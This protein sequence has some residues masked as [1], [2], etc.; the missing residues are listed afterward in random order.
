MTQPTARNDNTNRPEE[1]TEMTNTC[2]KCGEELVG[3]WVFHGLVCGKTDAERATA[4]ASLA[5]AL[6]RRAARDKA[7][8]ERRIAEDAEWQAEAERQ[9]E[10]RV[11]RYATREEG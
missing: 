7:D 5:E 1:V 8:L 4:G 2:E 11:A 6:E 3:I 9:D 10:A